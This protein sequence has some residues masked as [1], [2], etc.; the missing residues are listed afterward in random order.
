MLNTIIRGRYQIDMLLG[1]GGYGATYRAVDS[2]VQR[3]VALK[4]IRLRVVFFLSTDY[5]DNASSN[6]RYF[7]IL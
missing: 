5:L 4:A 2:T 7:C 6:G 3:V 1:K